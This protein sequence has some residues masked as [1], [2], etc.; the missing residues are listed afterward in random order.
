MFLFSHPSHQRS[1]SSM[2]SGNGVAFRQNVLNPLALCVA[3]VKR[4][5]LLLV[6]SKA[7][8]PPLPEAAA[9]LLAILVGQ[10]AWI[11]RRNF[12]DPAIA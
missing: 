8:Q 12:S 9:A 11:V 10:Q 2:R 3:A 5:D 6:A 1:A 4:A 7:Q